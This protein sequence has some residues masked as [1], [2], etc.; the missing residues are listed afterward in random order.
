MKNEYVII[1]NKHSVR[2]ESTQRRVILLIYI[3]NLLAVTK[4][5][6]MPR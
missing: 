6:V 2:G 5:T 3:K 4:D 1:S